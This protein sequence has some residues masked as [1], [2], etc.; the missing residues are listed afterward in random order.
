M[1]NTLAGVTAAL[2][3]YGLWIGVGVI[4]V[5]VLFGRRNDRSESQVKAAVHWMEHAL[6][7]APD[8]LLS[9]IHI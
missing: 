7:E 3:E 4:A 8:R 2:I 9:L 6:E 1:N 5:A